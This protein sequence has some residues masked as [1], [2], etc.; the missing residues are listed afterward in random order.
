VIARALNGGD[1]ARAAIAAVLTRTSELS[2][3]TAARLATADD[4]LTK[5][6]AD[7]PRDWRGR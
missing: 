3:E 7:E 6:N 1:F 4:E 2:C 5:Y